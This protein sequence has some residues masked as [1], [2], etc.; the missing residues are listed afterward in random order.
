MFRGVAVG[1]GA[2]HRVGST[3]SRPTPGSTAMP[4]PQGARGRSERVPMEG[5]LHFKCDFCV[6]PETSRNTTRTEYKIRSGYPIIV[7][8]IL[9]SLPSK[10]FSICGGF[11][12]AKLLS[13]R[14]SPVNAPNV[15]RG[16]IATLACGADVPDPLVSPPVRCDPSG[17]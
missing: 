6:I 2:L 8:R 17:R 7:H 14:V 4:K 10:Q 5:R 9:Y 15:W 12:G 11:A 3:R 1:A 13:M 16:V